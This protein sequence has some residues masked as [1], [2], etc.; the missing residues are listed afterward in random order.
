MLFGIALASLLVVGSPLLAR[1]LAV[2]AEL[3]IA[4]A[5]GVP[6]GL[7]FPLLLGEFQGEQ[8]FMALSVLLTGQAGVKLLAAITL[9]VVFGPLGVV[10]GLSLATITIYLVALRLLRRRLAVRANLS[11][12]RPAGRYLAVVLPATL[13]LAVL[14]SADVLLVKH[15]FPTQV[16]GEYSAVAALGRA[17]FW[18]ATG[19]AAVLFPKIVGKST[20][21]N[22]GSHLVGA[23]LVLVA[24]GGLTGLVF[25]SLASRWI[26][27]AFA[28]GAYV[29]GAAYL[30][31]YAAG[32]TLLG[33]VAVLIATHQSHGHARYLGVLIPLTIL[34]PVLLA[35]FHKNILQVVQVLDLSIAMILVALGVLY[36]VDE[37]VRRIASIHISTSYSREA[38][39]VELVTSQ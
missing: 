24:A 19:I 9:G 39:D 37:R 17:I 27:T 32:M 26:L 36:V 38:Q 14:L 1:S 10:A 16:A 2:P 35:M 33:G 21:G 25:L 5:V 22:T 18:G 13:A 31:W 3:L 6:F 20:R 23:S 4:A 8:R 15:F 7:A 12:W 34:E 30:P 28:G 29:G 11:W